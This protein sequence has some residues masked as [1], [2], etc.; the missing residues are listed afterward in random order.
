MN[1]FC[2]RVLSG[3]A[4]LSVYLPAVAAESSPASKGAAAQAGAESGWKSLF[5]GRTMSGWKKSGFDG[6]GAVKVE[7]PFRE[8]GGAIVIESGEF[9][10]GVTWT[11]EQELPRSNYEI[12]LDAMKLDGSDFFCGLTFPVRDSGCTLIVGGW[13]GMVVG[14][15]SI[16]NMDASENDTTGAME[17]APNRWYRIR[18]K[19]TDEKI[20]AWIDN[21][22]MFEVETKDRRIGL[23]WGDIDKSLPLGVATYQTRAAIR[24]MRL[25]KL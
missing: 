12:E 9:L 24:N 19:V 17:F 10:S 7:N 2:R 3:F 4:I 20:E 5:D 16:D 1:Q 13:G 11:R 6:E 23:R 25:R 14:L 21:R 18:L 8:G 15:S 22:Q